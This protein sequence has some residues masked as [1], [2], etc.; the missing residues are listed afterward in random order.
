M[1]VREK[2]KRFFSRQFGNIFVLSKRSAKHLQIHKQTY[3][4]I[5]TKPVFE[6]QTKGL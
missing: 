2:L 1:C 3:L 5:E 4:V 6:N